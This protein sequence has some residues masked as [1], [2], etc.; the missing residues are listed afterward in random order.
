[1]EVKTR[2]SNAGQITPLDAQI[3]DSHG[4]YLKETLTDGRFVNE[5]NL[6]TAQAPPRDMGFSDPVPESKAPRR[7]R[8]SPRP[9]DGE[10]LRAWRVRMGT[11][12]A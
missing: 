4:V 12:P 11:E 3:H 2:G 9:G 10:P 7:D 6:E 1:M 5:E 8:H